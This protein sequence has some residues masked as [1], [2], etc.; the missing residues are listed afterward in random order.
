MFWRD[1]RGPHS[2]H[3]FPA[4]SSK[5]YSSW[6]KD[7]VNQSLEFACGLVGLF[8]LGNI[9]LMAYRSV[10]RPSMSVFFCLFEVCVCVCVCV[11]ERERERELLSETEWERDRESEPKVC[12]WENVCVRER[13]RVCVG[14]HLSPNSAGIIGYTA[15]GA[16]RKVWDCWSNI[17]S[18]HARRLTTRCVSTGKKKERVGGRGLFVLS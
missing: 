16:L 15:E 17:V 10:T 1:T 6:R 18:K 14:G 13:E 11:R 5:Y 7:V 2:E 4:P 3:R 9:I 12:S 8:V